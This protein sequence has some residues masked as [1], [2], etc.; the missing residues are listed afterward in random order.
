MRNIFFILQII[1]F[2]IVGCDGKDRVHKSNTEVL[3]EHKLLDS[4]SEKVEYI[5]ETHTEINTDTIL[6]NGFRVKIRYLRHIKEYVSIEYDE[7]S[8]HHR[9]YYYDFVSKVTVYKDSKRD[10]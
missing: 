8:I 3:K 10:I 9:K 7:D 1:C 5:P 2:A 4:F 6:G